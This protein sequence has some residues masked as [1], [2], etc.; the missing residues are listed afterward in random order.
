M[1]VG[2]GMVQRDNSMLVMSFAEYSQVFHE[3][4]LRLEMKNFCINCR[5]HHEYSDSYGFDGCS[6]DQTSSSWSV[7]LNTTP[8]S[9]RKAD[10]FHGRACRRIIYPADSELVECPLFEEKK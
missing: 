7:I 4:S 6:C 2:D 8:D 5:F 10:D 1:K 9:Q 3:E